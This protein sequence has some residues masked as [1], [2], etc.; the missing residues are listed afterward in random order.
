MSMRKHW[1]AWYATTPVEVD[2]RRD[3]SPRH[4]LVTLILVA[5]TETDMKAISKAHPHMKFVECN[6]E[7]PIPTGKAVPRKTAKRQ[8]KLP[9]SP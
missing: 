8:A 1:E 9:R 3:G 5:H 4:V 7:A 2:P 6:V